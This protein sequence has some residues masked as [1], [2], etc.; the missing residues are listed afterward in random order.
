MTGYYNWILVNFIW[1]IS[2]RPGIKYLPVNQGKITWHVRYS[3][4]VLFSILVPMP[5]RTIRVTRGGLDW[6]MKSHPKSPRTTGSE[7][8]CFRLP[9]LWLWNLTLDRSTWLLF[10]FVF[11][12]HW[13]GAVPCDKDHVN[14]INLL[15]CSMESRSLWDSLEAFNAVR[16]GLG[17]V[18]RGA[19]ALQTRENLLMVLKTYSSKFL[20]AI[21]KGK[22]F[23]CCYIIGLTYGRI[24][25]LRIS[26]TM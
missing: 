24:E 23:C 9:S 19:K 2:K 7:A 12:L 10:N 20:Q 16:Y 6:Q 18:L 17:R 13:T 21:L 22:L 26:L 15:C 25:A 3:R 1:N 11:F 4:Q 5:V 8:D 14:Q